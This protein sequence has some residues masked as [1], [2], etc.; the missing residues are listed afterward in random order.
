[1]RGLKLL[2]YAPQVIAP[3][4]STLSLRPHPAAGDLVC[5]FLEGTGGQSRTVTLK[6]SVKSEVLEDGGAGGGGDGGQGEGGEEEALTIVV[7]ASWL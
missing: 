6:L 3:R 1:M 4:D 7:R 2:V 5:C